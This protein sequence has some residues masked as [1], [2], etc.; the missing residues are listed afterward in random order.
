MLWRK[1]LWYCYKKHSLMTKDLG[2][3][4]NHLS[5][6]DELECSSHSCEVSPLI[7]GFA[8]IWNLQAIRT[9]WIVS[10]KHNQICTDQKIFLPLFSFVEERLGTERKTFSHF[11]SVLWFNCSFAEV[12]NSQENLW[13]KHRDFRGNTFFLEFLESKIERER[14]NWAISYLCN[15][16]FSKLQTIQSKIKTKRLFL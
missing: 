2:L 10:S 8:A 11:N 7:L 16:D 13:I 5:S 3:F 14:L 4:T 12:K 6:L 15:L 1:I 9:L